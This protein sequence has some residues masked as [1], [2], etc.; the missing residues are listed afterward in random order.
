MSGLASPWPPVVA[1]LRR[2]AAAAGRRAAARRQRV[3]PPAPRAEHSRCLQLPPPSSLPTAGARRRQPVFC[4]LLHERPQRHRARD[5]GGDPHRQRCVEHGPPQERSVEP[6]REVGPDVGGGE[7]V[8]GA[9]R[10]DTASTGTPGDADDAVGPAASAPRRPASRSPA[11][12]PR[13]ARPRRPRR[14]Q[15]GQQP[16]LALVD[17]QRARA[18]S[19]S[20]KLAARRARARRRRRSPHRRARRP[21][22]SARRGIESTTARGV[23]GGELVRRSPPRP[24]RRSP[25]RGR[26]RPA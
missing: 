12:R 26:R 18:P 7:Q 5:R 17:D 23:D 11:A 25:S 10:V 16:R 1:F 9:G 24:G 6:R 22:R 3:R 4:A 20:G 21:A 15:P 19:R 14:R 13:P 8:A 2:V